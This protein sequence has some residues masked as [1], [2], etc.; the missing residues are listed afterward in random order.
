L[1]PSLT[2]DIPPLIWNPKVSSFGYHTDTRVILTQAS[3]N[4][5]G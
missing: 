5:K 3:M 2:M 1:M 4:R